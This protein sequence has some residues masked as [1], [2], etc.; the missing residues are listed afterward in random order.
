METIQH[1]FTGCSFARQVWVEVLSWLRA[2]CRP[3]TQDDTLISW[4]LEAKQATPK[5]LR[6]GLA[7]MTLLIPWMI[8]K[9]RNGFVFDGATPSVPGV[10]TKISVEAGIWARAGARGLIVVLPN[11]WDVH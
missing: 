2:T 8:W 5:T 11:T 10:V 6:K 7:S 1:L 9:E 4:W 3:P